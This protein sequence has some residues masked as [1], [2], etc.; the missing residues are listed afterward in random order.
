MLAKGIPKKLLKA[1]LR[2]IAEKIGKVNAIIIYKARAKVFR[3][4]A[5]IIRLLLKFIAVF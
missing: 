5:P 3:P 4:E 1:P 2:Q